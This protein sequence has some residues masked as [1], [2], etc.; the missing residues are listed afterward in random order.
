MS[1]ASPEF[2]ERLRN[3]QEILPI[4]RH[5]PV[6]GRVWLSAAALLFAAVIGRWVM[7]P[8]AGHAPEPTAQNESLTLA[9]ALADAASSTLELAR[10]T[11]APA[12]RVGRAVFAS[13][14]ASLP[15]AETPAPDVSVVPNSRVL[16]S[17]GGRVGAGVRPLSGSAR[18]AFGFLLRTAPGDEPVAP[19]P[20]HPRGT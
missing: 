12:G 14:S 17:V 15:D 11:S 2:V 19:K 5:S 7:M 8:P 9:G 10:E 20:P 13:A 6:S 18:N 16:R 4:Q 3:V 1:A